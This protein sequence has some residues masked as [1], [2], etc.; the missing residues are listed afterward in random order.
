M[1]LRAENARQVTAIGQVETHDAAMRAG[2]RSVN[3]EVRCAA[4]V[5][6]HVHTCRK[7]DFEMNLL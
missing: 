3:S 5:G 2:E 6:L 4:R 1:S 7:K